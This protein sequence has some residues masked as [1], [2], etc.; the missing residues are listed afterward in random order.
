MWINQLRQYKKNNLQGP[1]PLPISG[2]YFGIGRSG[3]N[4]YYKEAAKKYGKT[5]LIFF[6]S[7]PIVC[8]SDVEFVKQIT[9]KDFRLFPLRRV[10]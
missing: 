7:K 3:L 2:N 8:T 5:F 4:K 9:V 1:F 10:N 6:G